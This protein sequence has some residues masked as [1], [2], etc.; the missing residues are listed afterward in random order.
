MWRQG[1]EVGMHIKHKAGDKMF[2]D[3]AGDKL[4]Y[5]DRKTGKEIPVETFVAVL[6]GSGF[7]AP[8]STYSHSPTETVPG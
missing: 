4:C 7:T 3:Y 2:V 1:S 8:P 6:G 5:V